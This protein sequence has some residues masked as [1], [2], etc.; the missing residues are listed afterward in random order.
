MEG[1]HTTFGRLFGEQRSDPTAF[2]RPPPRCSSPDAAPGGMRPAGL[3]SP[4]GYREDFGLGFRRSVA[5]CAPVEAKGARFSWL[6]ED[7]A[8]PTAW[9]PKQETREC[10]FPGG[11]EAGFLGSRK[12]R[13]APARRGDS[14][15]MLISPPSTSRG[16][17]AGACAVSPRLNGGKG[18]SPGPLAGGNRKNMSSACLLEAVSHEAS[19]ENGMRPGLA[20]GNP[21]GVVAARQASPPPMTQAPLEDAPANRQRLLSANGAVAGRVPS[22]QAARRVEDRVGG[23]VFAAPKPVLQSPRAG[24]GSPGPARR[25]APAAEDYGFR[26]GKLR[27]SPSPP[28]GERASQSPRSNYCAG[29]TSSAVKD[30]E[31]T[32][33]GI[34]D[35][36][37]LNNV[38]RPL[39]HSKST[40]HMDEIRFRHREAATVRL[41]EG[42]RLKW[43]A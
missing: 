30:V 4:I 31:V 8:A 13:A 35:S 28:P 27:V 41:A 40:T 43:R 2:A 33:D 34:T 11:D 26:G 37:L 16:L 19:A 39:K 22:P 21:V 25:D 29:I 9:S 12:Q 1:Y 5:E 17:R 3:G 18:Q 24:Q 23:I 6:S 36:Q 7:G 38:P 15:Q 10:T 20:N 32:R 42:R 14:A